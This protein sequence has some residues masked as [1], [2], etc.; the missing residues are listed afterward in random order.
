M[1]ENGTTK[2][3]FDLWGVLTVLVAV[4]VSGFIYL[5]NT[6]ADGR[7]ARISADR[8]QEL[9]ILKLETD[10]TYIA[11]GIC[12]LKA[13]QEKLVNALYSLNKGKRE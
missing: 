1:A 13:G 9:R 8:S 4:A 2:V 11:S 6:L 7:Q 3:R 12:E 10:I 5:N